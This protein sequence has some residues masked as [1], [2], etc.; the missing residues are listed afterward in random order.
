VD[1]VVALL[2][3][4]AAMYGLGLPLAW[5]L[6]APE[7][8]AWVF[9]IAAGPL[10][11][12]VVT[13]AAAWLLRTVGIPLHPSQLLLLMVAA[14]SLAWW[15]TRRSWRVRE[16]LGRAQG[17]GLLVLLAG[18]G[19]FISLRGYGLYLPNRDFKNHAYFVAQVAFSQSS[20]SRLVLRAFPFDAPNAAPSGYPLGLHTLLG[21]ALPTTTWNSVGVTAAAAILATSVTLPLAMIALARLWDPANVALWWL[22]GLASIA[23]PG[24]TASFAVGAVPLLVGT[25]F[26]AAGLAALWAWLVRPTAS[27]G[28]AMVLCAFGLL[29]LHVAEAVA[30]A[31]VALACLPALAWRRR[32][33]FDRRAGAAVAVALGSIAVLTFVYIRPLLAAL[34]GDAFDIEPNDFGIAE[35]L[36]LPVLMPVSGTPIPALLWLPLV[37]LGILIV[38]RRRMSAF[39]L[40]ALG[41]AILLSVVASGSGLPPWLRP[42]AAPWYGAI[43][44][45]YLMAA[46]MV[47][48]LGSLTLAEVLR[49]QARTPR[50]AGSMV[51]AGVLCLSLL[52]IPASQLVPMRRQALQATLAG[53]GDTP[54]VAG[55]LA[56]LL[57]PGETVLNFEGDGGALLFAVGRLPIVSATADADSPGLAGHPY[58]VAIRGL[59]KVSD[60]EVAVA[61][62]DLGVGYLAVGT[63][64]L[65]WNRMTGHAM[66]R[67]VGQPEFTIAVQGTDLTILKYD[68]VSP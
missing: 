55:R 25:G 16:A 58:S 6:P 38:Y 42:L 52:A 35:A 2:L 67:L 12:I 17:P 51:L 39:P 18:V 27:T 68:G 66:E 10:Y 5:L 30:L 37:M 43:G 63:S 13:T 36:L 29:Y 1:I 47:L 54:A 50:R 48:L 21:W 65:Y 56:S 40:V 53:A 59:S 32:A 33:R 15:R 44:R 3:A 61:M 22:A 11:A 31:Y 60:P 46:P 4:A 34:S 26:Y 57:A 41:V 23:L 28:T 14:W 8:S 7:D 64:S 49:V 24:M 19:W 20:D 9:R 62:R 45:T